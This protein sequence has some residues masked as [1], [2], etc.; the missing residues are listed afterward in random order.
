MGGNIHTS[1]TISIVSALVKARFHD[2]S[3]LIIRGAASVRYFLES[4]HS[5]IYSET[6]IGRVL[7][8]QRESHRG[9]SLACYLLFAP[10]SAARESSATSLQG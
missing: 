9:P 6:I 5:P 2:G 8:W 7:M 3:F 1:L 10:F 4:H